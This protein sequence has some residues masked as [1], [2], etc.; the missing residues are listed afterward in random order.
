MSQ[1][2]LLRQFLLYCPYFMNRK[3]QRLSMIQKDTVIS[4]HLSARMDGNYVFFSFNLQYKQKTFSRFLHRLWFIFF[5]LLKNKY[6]T[7]FFFFSNITHLS[8]TISEVWNACVL[9]GVTWI[10]LLYVLNVL[11]V[12]RLALL[13]VHSH[14]M[15]T[16]D[17]QCYQEDSIAEVDNVGNWNKSIAKYL[18]VIHSQKTA[19]LKAIF[20]LLLM[21]PTLIILLLD[22]IC[23]STAFKCTGK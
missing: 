12:F 8:F 3:W 23:F 17:L 2:T 4:L 14:G 21:Q 9:S 10:H 6:L 13:R 15:V 1:L 22:H 20:W 11:S 7:F 5:L 16:I 18:S 19:W